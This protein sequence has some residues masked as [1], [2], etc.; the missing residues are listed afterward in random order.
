MNYKAASLY[1]GGQPYGSEAN[2]AKWMAG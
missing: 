2:M 1:D